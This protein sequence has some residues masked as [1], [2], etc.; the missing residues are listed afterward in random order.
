VGI[1]HRVPAEGKRRAC[2]SGQATFGGAWSRV[3]AE[4]GEENAESRIW[5]GV[6]YRVDAVDA[7]ATGRSVADHVDG[8]ELRPAACAAW[9]CAD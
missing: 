1:D 5:L 8:N 9:D 7:L 4:A 3:F 6:H 2:V